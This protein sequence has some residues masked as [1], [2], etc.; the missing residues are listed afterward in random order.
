MPWSRDNRPARP[1]SKRVLLCVCFLA[2][3][4]APALL[5]GEVGNPSVRTF[6]PRDY[7][8]Q[9]QNWAIVQAPDGLIYV[10][11]GEGVLEYDGVRW[12]L[13]PTPNRTPVRS[14]ALDA[15]GRIYVG[16]V[17]EVGYLAPDALGRMA[18]VPLNPRLDPAHTRFA[19]VWKIHPCAAGV[20][21][22]TRE[23][24]FLLTPDG[25]RH[26]QVERPLHNGF[27]VGDRF[28][29]Q[30][31]DVGLLELDGQQPRP[32]PCGDS[33]KQ[34]KIFTILPWG[35]R[36][37][38]G[39]RARGLLL[40]DGAR[41]T[42]FPTEA[43]AYLKEHLLYQGALLPDGTLALA[44]L[45]GG[46]VLLSR[47]GRLERI[48]DKRAGLADATVYTFCADRQGGLWMGL[49]NGLARLQWPAPFSRF[50]AA[51]GL[52]GTVLAIHRHGPDL[53]AGTSMGLFRLEPSAADRPASFKP[54]PGLKSQTWTI[55]STPTGLMVGNYQGLF[56]VREGRA[57]PVPGVDAAVLAALPG[58]DGRLYLGLDGG[59]ASLRRAGGA[60]VF[61]GR[62]PGVSESVHSMAEDGDGRLWLGTM[63]GEVLRVGFPGADPG[64]P[65]AALVERF[66]AA[67]GLP[68]KRQV[69]VAKVGAGIVFATN[70]GVCRFLEAERRFVPDPRFASRFE[71]GPRRVLL[72]AQ[73]AAGQVWMAT[74]DEA[75]SLHE[76]ALGR[77]DAGGTFRWEQAPFV[78]F[79]TME[80]D[81]IAA[82]PD[83]IAWLGGVEGLFRY[84]A[85]RGGTA[86]SGFGAQ[87]RGVVATRTGDLIR[88]GVR[89]E[90]PSRVAPGVNALRIDF[91]AASFESGWTNL[92]QIRL[93]GYD[94]DWSPWSPTPFKEY[95]YLPPGEY[96]FRVRAMD[97]TGA[98]SR[99]DTWAF[100]LRPPWYR[101]GWG[102][103]LLAL[104]VG[105]C[106]LAFHALVA[107]YLDHR[108]AP[109]RQQVLDTARELELGQAALAAQ[110][111]AMEKVQKELRSTTEE[112]NQFISMVGHDLRN[113]LNGIM[114][115]AELLEDAAVDPGV[116]RT[117]R[118]IRN[119]CRNM[120]N[121]IGRF[122]DMAAIEAG[123]LKPSP[124][125][126][127]LADFIRLIAERHAP[128]ATR[129]D[130]RL[131]LELDPQAGA[132]FTDAKFAQEI[133][134]NL[135]SNAVTFS[136]AGTT[137]TVGLNRS[138]SSVVLTVQDQGPGFTP[139]DLARLYTPFTRLSARPT[140]NEKAVGLGLS[141]VRHMVNAMPCELSLTTAPGQGAAFRLVFPTV[142][143]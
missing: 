107:R 37:L 75:T 82:D 115:A 101:S 125:L 77:P 96:V 28:F 129:K 103:S 7:G 110:A 143:G 52:E 90:A 24:I 109:L 88:G 14:L 22:F 121:L 17:G 57:V 139:E 116:N 40:Y 48:L 112:K 64:A 140:G 84:D 38:I 118:S 6:L 16:A 138:G 132:A 135:V 2:A 87:V 20:Y 3:L 13:I 50:D 117:A 1:W 56:E 92:Y 141:I 60:W 31:L 39:T 54:V 18:Y 108:T 137:V 53:Y 21:F 130:I 44:T 25:F 91:A 67:Q 43:D 11:N 72:L 76:L 69:D 111:F 119:E 126:C 35:G 106:L 86:S 83:G 46:T 10:G 81:A 62:Y 114:L 73:G 123:T 74:Q 32:L 105:G 120:D 127:S 12:R 51:N 113:P 78:R 94:R 122:L 89:P 131:S 97:A 59:L 65:G 93:D 42:P 41:L 71:G 36:L 47:E 9:S 128:R 15:H 26:W 4:L 68:V 29:I 63:G 58:R 30:E 66:G 85:A 142:A 95:S 134:D 45:G 49:S 136:P 34:D 61:E 80:L 79:G 124:T 27:G 100:T 23:F 102:V 33:F 19:E 133:L 5:G 8:A 55:A 70:E 104:L 99:E 98:T